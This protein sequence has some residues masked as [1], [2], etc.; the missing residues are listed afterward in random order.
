MLIKK[1]SAYILYSTKQGYDEILAFSQNDT[2]NKSYEI[3]G[4]TVEKGER[5]EEALTREI[6]EETGFQ[7]FT[8]EKKLGKVVYKNS[9]DTFVRTFFSV[10]IN[11]PM[12]DTFS[13]YVKGS[14][15]DSG[16]LY[17]FT[18]LSPQETLLLTPRDTHFL[19]RKFLPS[20]FTPDT[21]LG[22]SNKTISLMPSDVLWKK[23]FREEK[24]L[25]QKNIQDRSV[26][27]EHIGSTSIP[28]LAA[29]PIIDIGIGISDKTDINRLI[30]T[31]QKIGYEYKGENGIEGRHYF[32]KGSELQRRFH[33][34]TF[35][36]NAPEW[37]NHLLF[38][39]KLRSNKTLAKQYESLKIEKWKTHYGDRAAYTVSKDEFI[40][41][42]LQS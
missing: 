2:E 30:S 36:L 23:K 5:L 31:M 25:I 39:N 4:G 12:Q 42:V 34:H 10:R 40:K 26:I 27:I 33:V 19:S 17:N 9:T 22:L 29:K 1:V 14:G 21:L 11:Q 16:S 6:K 35:N 38:R 3:P 8:I 7:E 37:K 41:S 28:G 24:Q 20:V 13:N 18:W 32:V 15:K